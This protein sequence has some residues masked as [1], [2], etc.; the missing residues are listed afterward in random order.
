MKPLEE[1][2]PAVRLLHDDAELWPRVKEILDGSVQVSG[3]DHPK[4]A[5]GILTWRSA[6]RAELRE[7]HAVRK[8]HQGPVVAILAALPSARG[9]RGMAARVE[10]SVMAQ[11]LERALLPTLAAVW[12]G[13]CVV[14]RALRQM[15]DTPPLSPRERQILAMVVLGFTNAEIARKL[16]VT[17]SN[18]KSHLT[19]AFTKLGVSSRSAASELILDGESGVGLGILRITQED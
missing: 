16:V 17:E 8:R 12:V 13:Q 3:D 11:E 15:V 7:L 2:T 10:G 18:V 14:P 1:Q 4:Q 5:I 6:T 9:A 19:S